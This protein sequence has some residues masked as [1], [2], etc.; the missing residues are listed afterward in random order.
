MKLAYAAQMRDL[1][2]AAIKTYGIPEI[3]LMENAGI[4]TVQAILESY[5]ELDSR[6][7]L[8]IA[9]QG[10]NGGDGL[11]IARH[12]LQRGGLPFIFLLT[13]PEKL[14]GSAAVNLKIVKNLDIPIYPITNKTRIKS[15]RNFLPECDLIIDAIFG[16]GLK[17][18][19]KDHFAQAIELINQT[20]VP[21]ISVDIPSGLDSDTG[22]PK[23]ICIKANLTV[24]YGLAKPGH[25]IGLGAEMSGALVV[26][27]ISIPPVV[28]EEAA[29][30]IEVLENHTVGCLI[31]DRPAASHKGT[32]GHLLVL[33]G[34]RGKTGAALLC[35]LGALRSGAGL[36]TICTPGELNQIYETALAE[37]MTLPLTTSDQGYLAATD[38]D[39]INEDMATK[40][41]LVI[42]PGLGQEA[43]TGQLVAR[44]YREQQ[45]PMVVDADGLNLL[46]HDPAQLTDPPEVRILTPHPGEMARLTGKTTP[47]IQAN[48]LEVARNFATKHNVFLVLKGA[49]TI[50]A[51]PSGRA[52][53]N[54]SGNPTLATGGSGDVLAGFI[55]S[56][57]AQGYPPWE[58]ACLGVYAHGIAADRLAKDKNIQAGLL[59]SELA[60]ELPLVMAELS[61]NQQ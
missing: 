28:L 40:Q 10:N 54:A 13:D 27:D 57:L 26:V 36:V 43:T 50:I 18:E 2:I 29:L 47:E 52:A 41:A 16:I 12:I 25:F 14:K 23:G 61:N 53:I 33:A 49:H 30:Q 8:I 32:Y 7:V 20:P 21:V 59:A 37:A 55:G 1:D 38:Y 34:S 35:A 15:L 44:L 5:G 48:R 39:E 51:E 42:G 9:G 4:G 22:I 24:T 46:A 11:V 3:V 17:R 6:T 31:P 56:L 60:D 58:A 19:V 45:L